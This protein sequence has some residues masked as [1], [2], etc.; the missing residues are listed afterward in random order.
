M[1][2]LHPKIAEVTERIRQRSAETRAE[3]LD[4]IRSRR[5]KGF[6]RQRLSEGNLAH[7]SAGCAVIE[8][9]H[10]LGAGWP[11]IGII[12]AYND[13]LSAHAPFEHYPEIIREA[14]R[15]VHAVAQVAGGVPAMCDGVTQGQQGMELSLFSRDV[16]AMA[17][18]IGLSHDV[19]DAALHLGVCDKIVPGL[20]IAALRFGWIP[21]IFVPAGPM[22]SG[23]PNPEKVRIRQLF[24]E[25]KVDRSALL[26]A[27]AESYHAQGTCTFYGTANSNQ[28]LMEVM[29][30]HLPGAAFTNPGTPLRKALTKA[31]THRAA[32]ITAQGDQY[33]PAGELIDER[34]IVNGIVGLMATGGSTNHALHIPA[35]AAAAGIIVTL[36]DFAEISHVTP[37]LTRIYPNGPADVN[38]FHAAGGMG[39]VVRELLGAGL[40]NGEAQGV[41]GPISHYS[42]EPFL[43]GD[44]VSW[45]PAPEESGD[46]DIIRPA[47]DP[48]SA[49]GGLRLM[50]GPLGRGVSKVSAVK[51]DKR[52]LEAP[53]I[54][55]ESQEALKEAFEAGRLDRDFVAVVRFQGPAANG[56]PELHSLTPALGVLQDRGFKVALVTD[57]RMSGASGKVPSAIHISPEAARGGPLARVRDGDVIIF[58]AETGTLDIKVD[59]SEFA[60]RQPAEFRPNASASGL[61]R[62]MFTYFRQMSGTADT[63]AS[64]FTFV[65]KED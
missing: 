3:Y 18:A 55:F 30:F 21:S 33:L 39:F 17:S 32:E 26:K 59:P 49:D 7:A 4:M 63:G 65:T 56:M 60:A 42:H 34:S 44:K 6:A 62:E 45:R 31:A 61:G 27:E 20:V 51:P 22:P 46:L 41:G 2:S 1:T 12:T 57:G 50:T 52:V 15:E 23:L 14:A 36:E 13:M 28:M 8:K 19:F 24:A 48:F 64:Q 40:L 38:H 10:L 53:A 37:L 29:G 25:G 58:N 43:D 9:T 11:N 35:M 47:S 16:I 5:P 54:V